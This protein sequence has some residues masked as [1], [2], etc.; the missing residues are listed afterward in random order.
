MKVHKYSN[1]I[2]GLTTS[3]NITTKWNFSSNCHNKLSIFSTTRAVEKLWIT[4]HNENRGNE[5]ADDVAK[6]EAV[7][8]LIGLKPSVGIFYTEIKEHFRQWENKINK[9][10]W[11]VGK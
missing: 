10:S 9:K 11:I 7:W 2:I 6:L 5:I 4:E 3:Q 1:N 8:P